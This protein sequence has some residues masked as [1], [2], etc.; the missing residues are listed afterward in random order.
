MINL[1]IHTQGSDTILH[2]VAHFD[3]ATIL[4][5][6]QCFRW[7]P[8]GENAYRGTV[9][10][11]VRTLRQQGT[12]VVFHDVSREEFDRLWHGYFDFD[13]D[14]GAVKQILCRD[15]AMA[16]AVAFAPGMRVLRQSPWETLCS[17]IISANNNIPRIQG[18]IQRL[19]ELLGD[20]LDGGYA[21]PTPERLAAA[22]PEDLAPIRAGYRAAYLI[23]AAQRMTQGSLQLEPLYT[24]PLPEARKHLQQVKG[25]GPKVAECVLLYGFARAEC[26]PVDVWIRRAIDALYPAGIPAQI[27]PVA[28]LGQQYLFHYVR[29][30]PEALAEGQPAP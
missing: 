11:V 10:G 23:D 16:R 5:S 3:L 2:D 29:H 4:E 22:T 13:R 25:V 9:E 30:C 26:V 12:D 14:Y 19:C 24:S 21:F 7:E 15:P 27:Q 28:G 18:I 1:Q 6:G 8:V 17:F 20:P